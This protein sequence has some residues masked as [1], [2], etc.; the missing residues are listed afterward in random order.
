[1]AVDKRP[2]RIGVKIWIDIRHG[3][4][5]KHLLRTNPKNLPAAIL[6]EFPD[7]I[8]LKLLATEYKHFRMGQVADVPNFCP[9]AAQV[10]PNLPALKGAL[11]H[12]YDPS[13]GKGLVL[14]PAVF[15]SLE[16]AGRRVGTRTWFLAVLPLRVM[17]GKHVIVRHRK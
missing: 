13:E 1:V 5:K 12:D 14:L 8:F 9:E 2:G 4:R 7:R 3:P 10:A 15:E 17:V 11:S 16:D 6:K